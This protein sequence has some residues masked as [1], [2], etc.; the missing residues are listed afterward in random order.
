MFFTICR[1]ITIL[2]KRGIS[3]LFYRYYYGQ[4][5]TQVHSNPNYDTVDGATDSYSAVDYSM[6][7]TTV[8]L[9][10]LLMANLEDLLRFNLND[11]PNPKTRDLLRDLIILHS[12]EILSS[13]TSRPLVQSR[14]NSITSG[15]ASPKGNSDSKVSSVMATLTSSV[16]NDIHSESKIT[17]SWLYSSKGSHELL[18]KIVINYIKVYIEISSQ[19][20][21]KQWHCIIELLLFARMY[22]VLPESLADIPCEYFGLISGTAIVAN[23]DADTNTAVNVVNDTNL[24]DNY[25]ADQNLKVIVSPSSE[26]FVLPTTRYASRFIA[27][28][29]APM[30]IS[31]STSNIP[32]SRNSSVT[33]SKNFSKYNSFSGDIQGINN[34]N[35]AYVGTPHDSLTTSA[36]SSSLWSLLFASGND[37]GIKANY[38]DSVGLRQG[39]NDN[40]NDSSHHII[41]N[42]KQLSVYLFDKKKIPG[43]KNCEYAIIS[44]NTVHENSH[45]NVNGFF[46]SSKADREQL[47]YIFK[48][49]HICDIIDRYAMK[50]NS[51]YN[52]DIEPEKVEELNIQL[53]S[54]FDIFMN[55]LHEILHSVTSVSST[56]ISSSISSAKQLINE[57]KNK[58]NKYRVYSK[59]FALLTSSTIVASTIAMELDAVMLLEWIVKIIHANSKL[60]SWLWPKLHKSKQFFNVSSMME[61]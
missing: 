5:F 26:G 60:V 19:D 43:F 48:S 54:I 44:G 51:E 6:V 41:R 55:F 47:G 25:G 23:T 16:S 3:L 52:G 58:K 36:S 24:C 37:D 59:E 39:I 20:T 8:D 11:S 2:S 45:C 50:S 15:S 29:V 32:V 13:V 42:L 46:T 61:C 9:F 7:S 10:E 49:S 1:A 38:N 12:N 21:S 18:L 17:I 33:K 34:Y 4:I 27:D 22:H 56:T 28:Y 14:S 31:S 40:N 57:I 35:N 53:V 30:H